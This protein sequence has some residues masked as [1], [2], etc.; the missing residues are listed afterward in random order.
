[1]KTEELSDVVEVSRETMLKL[2]DFLELHR[3]GNSIKVD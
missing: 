3:W 2:I 1:M